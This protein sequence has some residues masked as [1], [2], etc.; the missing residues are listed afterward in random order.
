MSLRRRL[1]L[2]QVGLLALGLAVAGA[3]TFAA[4][5]DWKSGA[6]RARLS[7]AGRAAGEILAARPADGATPRLPP[8]ETALP[9]LWRAA[10]ADGGLPLYFQVRAPD[11]AVVQTVAPAGT[12]PLPRDPRPGPVT[13]DGADGERFLRVDDPAG[14]DG[15]GPFGRDAPGWIVR[16]AWTPDR[17][18]ILI[19]AMRTGEQD[20]LFGRTLGTQVAVTAAV[21]LGVGLLGGLA[22]RRATRPLAEIAAAA[23]RIGDVTR[24]GDLARRV[25]E[26]APAAGT[27]VGRL[28]AALN[29]MLA[30]IETAFREREESRDRLRR[31]VADASHELRTPVAI[32]RGY[33]ELFRRG[34]ADRPADLATAMRRIESEAERMGRL[35]DEMLLLARLDEGR[36]L[37]RGPVDLAALAEAAVADAAVV[38]PAR[39][40][41]LR[42]GGPVVVAGDREGLRR[43]L[44]NLLANVRAHTPPGTAATVRVAARDGGAV[45]E[46]EDDGPGLRGDGDRVFER[47]HRGPS[48]DGSRTPDRGGAGLGLSIVA[49]VARAHGG[50]AG[51]ADAPGGGAVLTVVL[52]AAEPGEEAAGEAAGNP[53]NV[54]RPTS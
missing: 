38:D 12:P 31:F 25:P 33:A 23:G 34:A 41:T 4:F 32:V 49:A 37:E 3:S 46:V 16:A 24:A 10:A 54:T 42:T 26:P 52:P 5:H 29:A 9:R 13:G 6:E 47:F 36:P 7:A 43:V 39:P 50:R 40:L 30:Q 11:G 51:A 17:R 1:V 48:G 20:E 19:T 45:L 53:V 21:L 44:D 18:A 27:E 14:Q 35:V 28:A 22:V 15:A 2:V 8:A